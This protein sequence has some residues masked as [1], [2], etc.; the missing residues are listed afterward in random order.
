MLKLK[1]HL[2]YWRNCII[3]ASKLKRYYIMAHF[4]L[5]KESVI[6]ALKLSEGK[7]KNAYIEFESES[8][9]INSVEYTVTTIRAF[10]KKRT[11]KQEFEK[12]YL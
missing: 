9:V 3:F 2:F 7:P 11:V 5:T 12:L 4:W 8:K 1:K 6:E 10:G